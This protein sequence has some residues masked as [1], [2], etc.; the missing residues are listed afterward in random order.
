MALI[1]LFQMEAMLLFPEHTMMAREQ[2]DR[3]ISLVLAHKTDPEQAI[4]LSKQLNTQTYGKVVGYSLQP[5]Y[6][7]SANTAQ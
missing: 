4:S 1:Y 6:L 5:L 7:N 2:I 3:I